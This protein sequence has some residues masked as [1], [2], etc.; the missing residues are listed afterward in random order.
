MSVGEVL[1]GYLSRDPSSQWS[2]EKTVLFSEGLN[3]YL[4]L[5]KL[6][7]IISFCAPRELIL[8]AN[9]LPL[10]HTDEL[11]ASTSYGLIVIGRR[12]M[13]FCCLLVTLH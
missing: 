9:Y 12:E 11:N 1:Y 13:I 3:S 8:T 10:V 4:S 6:F 2:I 7:P 5:S